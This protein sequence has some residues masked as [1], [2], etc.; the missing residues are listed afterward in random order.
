METK[1]YRNGQEVNQSL[2]VNIPAVTE[3]HRDCDVTK[4][5]QNKQVKYKSYYYKALYLVQY[6]TFVC[7][8]KTFYPLFSEFTLPLDCVEVELWEKILVQLSVV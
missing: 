1:K 7:N 2:L 5:V 4:N 6:T 8:K 3:N